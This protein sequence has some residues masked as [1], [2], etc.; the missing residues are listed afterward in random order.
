MFSDSTS[1]QSVLMDSLTALKSM[2]SLFP[3]SFRVPCLRIALR[4]QLGDWIL[5]MFRKP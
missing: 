5:C 4:E 3:I 1:L 2:L